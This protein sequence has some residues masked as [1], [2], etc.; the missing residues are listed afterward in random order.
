MDRVE[1]GK[2]T[3]L[4]GSWDVWAGGSGRCVCDTRR[5]FLAPCRLFF[6]N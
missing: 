4:A 3:R 5:S 2:H 1:P 6:V